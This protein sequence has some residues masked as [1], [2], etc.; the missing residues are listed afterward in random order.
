MGRYV[1]ELVR[2]LAELPVHIIVVCNAHDRTVFEAMGVAVVVAPALVRR[3]AARLLWEQIGL[4]RLA[5]RLHV[6]VIH[7]VHY[8]TPLFTTKPRVITIHDLTFFSHPQF[9]TFRQTV[10]FSC[11]V[12]VEYAAWATIVTNSEA[13]ANAYREKFRRSH[14]EVIVTL[15]GG[16]E[17]TSMFLPRSRSK[18]SSN[19][20]APRRSRGLRS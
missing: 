5:K 7:S 1:E 9:H 2:H 20:S 6:S 17:K 3:T 18:R 19:I 13:T 4:P 15:F 11:L 16:N 10:V 14:N 8:T 12:V